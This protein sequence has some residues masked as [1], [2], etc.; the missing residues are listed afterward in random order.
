LKTNGYDQADNRKDLTLSVTSSARIYMTLTPS[1]SVDCETLLAELSRQ[2]DAQLALVEALTAAAEVAIKH[3]GSGL[4]AL[5]KP[6][7]RTARNDLAKANAKMRYQMAYYEMIERKRD[8]ELL[9]DK[10][11][12]D[13]VDRPDGVG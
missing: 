11:D 6:F 2:I 9:N 3:R 10:I 12:S 13:Q 1:P 4:D 5:T 8:L 7:G